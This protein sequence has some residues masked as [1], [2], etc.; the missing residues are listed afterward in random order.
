MWWPS[1]SPSSQRS[2]SDTCVH[3]R[4]FCQVLVVLNSKVRTC[5]Q[6][7]MRVMQSDILMQRASF[8]MNS[9]ISN[10]SWIHSLSLV[11]PCVNMYLSIRF[12]PWSLPDETLD[13]GNK[14]SCPFRTSVR[15]DINRYT[16]LR[17]LSSHRLMG[18]PHPSFWRPRT[19]PKPSKIQITMHTSLRYSTHAPWAGFA[20]TSNS[21]FSWLQ[22]IPRRPS[23]LRK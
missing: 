8:F 11:C 2:S 6:T 23:L 18:M 5:A 17:H 22:F 14:V 13:N 3:R 15:Q 7:M 10:L 9:C 19:P 12:S 21:K 16:Y 4:Y 20:R 1:V